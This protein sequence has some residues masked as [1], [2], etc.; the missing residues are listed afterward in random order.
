MRVLLIAL[1]VMFVRSICL[2]VLAQTVPL[3]LELGEE[4]RES[5]FQWQSQDHEGIL[6]L[7]L[8]QRAFN[9]ITD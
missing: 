9:L 5:L 2:A 3:N 6:G 8:L 7:L 4:F 1:P